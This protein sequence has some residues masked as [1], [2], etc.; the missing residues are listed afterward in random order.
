MKLIIAILVL[1]AMTPARAQQPKPVPP[2]QPLPPIAPAQVAPPEVGDI[3]K[4]VHDVVRRSIRLGEEATAGALGVAV[5][6]APA[7][8]QRAEVELQDIHANLYSNAGTSRG[9]RS[10]VIQSTEPDPVATVNAEEDLAIMSRILRKAVGNSQDEGRR[11]VLGT[12]VSVFG[13][14][15]GARNIYLDGYG[16][17]FLLSVRYP[18]IAP[19]EKRDEV[20][21]KDTI[22]DEWKEA[23]DELA[24]ELQGRPGGYGGSSAGFSQNWSWSSTRSPAEDFDSDK[25]DKLKT[26]LFEALKNATHMRILKPNDFVTVVVQGAEAVRVESAKRK[27]APPATAAVGKPGPADSD[28]KPGN[29]PSKVVSKSSRKRTSLGETVM[30]LRVKKSDVDAFAQGKLDL[31]AF[32]KKASLQTYFRRTDSTSASAFMPVAR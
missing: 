27:T 28:G 2:A 11:V 10:L 23:R 19:E 4:S 12:E 17:L 26:S 5:R 7:A 15:S 29:T 16:A 24:D 3:E 18:L 20:K 14:A 32:R 22:S 25:V 8:L 6:A 1:F 9:N 21:A 30:T 13:S 31:D